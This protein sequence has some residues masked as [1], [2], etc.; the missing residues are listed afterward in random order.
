MLRLQALTVKS[1][2]LNDRT[3]Q[4][5]HGVSGQR[6]RGGKNTRY[7]EI[8]AGSSDNGGTN[9]GVTVQTGHFSGKAAALTEIAD[10]GLHPRDGAMASGDLENVHWHKSSLAIYVLDGSF[11]TKDVASDT[12]LMA[13]A[14]DL[15]TIPAGTLHAARCPDPATYVVGFESAEAMSR[16]Q[17]EDPESLPGQS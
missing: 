3:E 11:E 7:S 12:T 15:I 8:T 16:F 4:P 14:G 5:T 9:M 2:C 1:I 17:P 13:H 6:V 10:R